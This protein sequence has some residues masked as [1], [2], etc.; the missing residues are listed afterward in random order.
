VK[1]VVQRV[2]EARVEVGDAVVGRI[3]RG[4]LVYLGCAPGDDEATT[5]GLARRLAVAR[6]FADDAGR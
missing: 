6:V 5:D 3:G 2:L 1:A 4:L